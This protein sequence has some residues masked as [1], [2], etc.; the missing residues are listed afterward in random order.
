M[1]KISL[2][3][4]QAFGWCH[5]HTHKYIRKSDF[6]TVNE[7]FFRKRYGVYENAAQPPAPRTEYISSRRMSR[8]PGGLR[9]NSPTFDL[10]SW[11]INYLLA[12]AASLFAECRNHALLWREGNDT[13]SSPISNGVPWGVLEAWGGSDSASI[14]LDGPGT[15]LQEGYDGKSPSGNGGPVALLRGTFA[16]L[17]AYKCVSKNFC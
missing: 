8:S 5:G 2:N 14:V 7:H 11:I 12:L 9:S 17:C 13:V 1:G 15:D 4:S 10:P 16:K 6:F 3:S